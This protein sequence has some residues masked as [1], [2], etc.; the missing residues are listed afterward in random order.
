MSPDFYRSAL[1]ALCDGYFRNA[2]RGDLPTE[3]CCADPA[4]LVS[5]VIAEEDGVRDIAVENAHN[6][7]FIVREG[8]AAALGTIGSYVESASEV[9]SNADTDLS[10]CERHSNL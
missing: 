1:P 5:E 4:E 10:D 2:D 8:T 6:A 9:E 3:F 7:D